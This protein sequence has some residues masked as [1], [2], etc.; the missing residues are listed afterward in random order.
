M[1]GAGVR[2]LL[3]G[4]VTM[5]AMPSWAAH[6]AN[7]SAARSVAT[8]NFVGAAASVTVTNDV[9]SDA[10]ALGGGS[11]AGGGLTPGGFTNFATASG[12]AGG[13]SSTVTARSSIEQGTISIRADVVDPPFPSVTAGG[14]AELIETIWFTNTSAQ[15][16]PLA[17]RLELDGA[18]APTLV[19]TGFSIAGRMR[20]TLQG[21]G[22]NLGEFIRLGDANGPQATSADTAFTAT[23]NWISGFQSFDGLGNAAWWTLTALPG[24]DYGGGPFN[25][26]MSTILW[27]PTGETTLELNPL[28]R[29]TSCGQ[30]FGACDFGNTARARF[31]ALPSGLSWTSQ[32]GLFLSGLGNGAVP[33]P[34]SWAMLI[35]GFG[36]TGAVA[37]RRRVRTLAA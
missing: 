19:D 22:N 3:A 17:F 20:S 33:E 28:L 11:V 27:V 34:A 18:I 15:W 29:I 24:N 30:G 32:S 6:V 26:V 35:A 8:T 25:F 7:G 14:S 1:S 13:R 10:S 2:L 16:Q 37:R 4:A 36:L 5:L 9:T 31:G 12:S 23:Y 21:A